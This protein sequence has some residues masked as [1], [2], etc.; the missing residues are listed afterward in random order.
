MKILTFVSL[1]RRHLNKG[2]CYTPICPPK[3]S[4]H[5]TFINTSRSHIRVSFLFLLYPI[6]MFALEGL[7]RTLNCVSCTCA[8]LDNI[9]ICIDVS[10]N[11]HIV[12]GGT[13]AFISPS[14]STEGQ[15]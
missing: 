4:H 13:I 6:F 10:L 9:K 2:S 12:G 11:V 3:I 1:D 8:L 5:L 7:P 15:N 14:P